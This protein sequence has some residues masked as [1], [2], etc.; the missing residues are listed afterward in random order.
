M[1]TRD[2]L[3]VSIL[4]GPDPHHTRPVFASE[5][6]ALIRAVAEAVARQLGQAETDAE[7]PKPALRG[8]EA[9]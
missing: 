9:L 4:K 1:G 2:R 6:P 7:T 5:D 3:F 8:A